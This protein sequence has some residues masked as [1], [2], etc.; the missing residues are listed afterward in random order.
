MATVQDLYAD[1]EAADAAGDT[2]KAKQLA[3]LIGEIQGAPT[4]PKPPSVGKTLATNLGGSFMNALRGA[5]A[6]AADYTGFKDTAASLDAARAAS[7]EEMKKAGSDTLLGEAAGVVGGMSPALAIE[8]AGTAAAP[9]TGGL[10]LVVANALNAGFFGIPAFRDTYKQQKEE[11]A[12]DGVAIQH[13]L[14]EASLATIGGRLIGSGSKAV[15]GAIKA[16]GEGLTKKLGVAAV[17]G[18]A[19]PEASR[20][21][22]KTIDAANN[23]ENEKSWLA[24]P[25]SMA[26]SALGFG[27]LHGVKH[28]TG[29]EGRADAKRIKDQADAAAAIAAKKQSEE[30][31]AAEQVAR[32]QDPAYLD[33]LQQRAEAF[34]KQRQELQAAAKGKADPND[35]VALAERQNAKKALA[36]FMRDEDNKA[37]IT[38]LSAGSAALRKR[39]A[40]KSQA[41]I[42]AQKQT[43]S[44]AET[45]ANA[46]QGLL[47]LQGGEGGKEQTAGEADVQP[48]KQQVGTAPDGSPLFAPD[49]MDASQHPATL[50]ASLTQ[51]IDALKAKQQAAT[52]L[53]QKI[54]IGRQHDQAIAARDEALKQAKA[55][56]PS[57]EEQIAKLQKDMAKADE[58][59]DAGTSGKLAQ[60]IKDLQETQGFPMEPFKSKVA[61][62]PN[63]LDQRDADLQKSQSPN[64]AKETYAQK[65]AREQQESAA[66]ERKQDRSNLS[67][68][69]FTQKFDSVFDNGTGG[70]RA[71]EPP[72]S[73]KPVS[74]ADKQ[75]AA[76][77]TLV[78]AI[79]KARSEKLTARRANEKE[80]ASAA[81]QRERDA[82]AQLDGLTSGDHYTRELIHR[83]YAQQSAMDTLMDVA[84][85]L[86]QGQFLGYK[87]GKNQKPAGL[88]ADLQA[89]MHDMM[90]RRE[91]LTSMD[92]KLG[93]ATDKAEVQRIT[94]ELV[95]LQQRLNEARTA[96][97]HEG[98]KDQTDLASTTKPLLYKKADKARAAYVKAMLEEAAIHR[99]ARGL[100][101]LTHEEALKAASEM[102]DLLELRSERKDGESNE[103]IQKRLKEIQDGLNNPD[104]NPTR[105]KPYENRGTQVDTVPTQET[106]LQEDRQRGLGEGKGTGVNVQYA[107]TEAARVAEEK[108]ENATTL[109]G[110]L[111]K[112]SEYVQ[113]LLEKA[114][115]RDMPANVREALEKAQA[116]LQEG[117]VTRDLLDA[118]ETQATRVLE[119]RMQGTE[120]TR[121]REL[122]KSNSALDAEGADLD[123]VRK[124][125]QERLAALNNALNKKLEKAKTDDERDVITEEFRAKR[126]ALTDKAEQEAR[127]VMRNRTEGQKKPFVQRS[128]GVGLT[129]LEELP[130][131]PEAIHDAL[132]AMRGEQPEQRGLFDKVDHKDAIAKNKEKIADLEGTI[133]FIRKS[134]MNRWI[135]VE[136]AKYRIDDAQKK[137]EALKQRN[138]ELAQEEKTQRSI[139]DQTERLGT[140]EGEQQSYETPSGFVPDDQSIYPRKSA[141]STAVLGHIRATAENFAR[142]PIVMK[143]RHAF[144]VLTG[145]TSAERARANMYQ[146]YDMA[147][148]HAIDDAGAKLQ[149]IAQKLDANAWLAT[150]YPQLRKYFFAKN[151]NGHPILDFTLE[152]IGGKE[153]D[154]TK[155]RL[156]I[157]KLRAEAAK[158]QDQLRKDLANIDEGIRKEAANDPKV[159]AAKKKL[160]KQQA[161]AGEVE[162]QKGQLQENVNEAI[163]EAHAARDRD[164]A[165]LYDSKISPLEGK[166]SGLEAQLGRVREMLHN[167][168]SQRAPAELLKT[169]MGSFEDILE[170]EFSLIAN[171]I[172][173]GI[174]KTQAEIDALRTARDTHFH[175]T[176]LAELQDNVTK[177]KDKGDPTEYEAARNAVQQHKEG[178]SESTMVTGEATKNVHVQ[179]AFKKLEKLQEK[180]ERLKEN[181]TPEEVTAAQK[182]VNEQRAHA[183]ELRRMDNEQRDS[184]YKAQNEHLTNT[185]GVKGKVL[186]LQRQLAALEA[187]A[188]AAA[189]DPK[190]AKK[191]GDNIVDLNRQILDL[192]KQ[193]AYHTGEP[194]G[195]SH[196]DVMRKS[197]WLQRKERLEAMLENPKLSDRRRARVQATLDYMNHATREMG[198][199]QGGVWRNQQPDKA[200]GGTGEKKKHMGQDRAVVDTNQIDADAATAE[201]MRRKKTPEQLEAETRAAE[202]SL[203]ES[204]R[205]AYVAQKERLEAWDGLSAAQKANI[206]AKRGTTDQLEREDRVKSMKAAERDWRR[207]QDAVN[208]HLNTGDVETFDTKS[209]GEPVLTVDKS[210]SSRGETYTSRGKVE[211]AHTVDS[212]VEELKPHFGG[213]DVRKRV[214]VFRD[215]AALLKAHPEYEGRI[216]EDAKGFVDGKHAFLIAENIG[217]GDGL[218]VLVHEI[219][220]HIGMRNLFP[221]AL[222]KALI[223]AVHDWSG[224]KDGSLESK[225]M[226]AAKARVEEAGTA[227]HKYDDE[228][229]AHAVEEAMKAGVTPTSLSG[230]GKI[231]Q[232]IGQAMQAMHKVLQRYGIATGAMKMQHLVDMAYG[233]AGKELKSTAPRHGGEKMFAYAGEKSATANNKNLAIAKAALNR[234]EHPKDVWEETGWFKGA[235]G[236]WRYELDDSKAVIETPNWALDK[237]NEW[238]WNGTPETDAKTLGDVLKHPTLYEAYPGLEKTKFTYDFEDTEFSKGA[239]KRAI[240]NSPAEIVV[241]LSN[242]DDVADVHDTVMHE[243]QHLLQATEGHEGGTNANTISMNMRNPSVSNKIASYFERKGDTA[244]RKIASVF[245]EHSAE[246][247]PLFDAYEKAKAVSAKANTAFKEHD[248]LV[249]EHDKELTGILDQ[250]HKLVEELGNID[251]FDD[252]RRQE[253]HDEIVA[254]HA[255]HREVSRAYYDKFEDLLNKSSEADDAVTKARSKMFAKSQDLLSGLTYDERSK[256]AFAGYENTYG[257]LEANDAAKRR[258]LGKFARTVIAPHTGQGTL[259]EEML[260][261]EDLMF[262]RGKSKIEEFGRDFTEQ[263]SK[264]RQLF[265]VRGGIGQAVRQG[266]MDMRASLR[267]ALS[268]GDK[269]TGVQAKTT[270]LMADSFVNNAQSVATEGA[271][272]LKKDKKGIIQVVFGGSRSGKDFMEAIADIPAKNAEA[273][274]AIMQGY[275]TA[276]RA[277]QQGWH[278]LDT[279][280]TAVTEA[281]GKAALAE[282]NADPAMKAAVEKAHDI[283]RDLNRGMIDFLEQT[284]ALP[285]D[286]IAKMK[287]DKN[288]VPF[289]RENGNN[290]EMLMPDGHPVS[291]GDIR[292]LPFLQA[293]KGDSKKLMSLPDAMLRNISTLTNLG[294][295][296]LANR[297]IGYHLA[298]IGRT[299]SGKE[300]PM[301]VRRGM[302]SEDK[303]NT[304]R[305]HEAPDPAY[306]RDTGDRYIEIDTRGTIA[307]HIPNDLLVQSVAGS[308]STF[309][310]LADVANSVGGILRTGITRNPMYVLGQLIKDPWNA[311]MSGNLKANPM[312]AIARSFK[313]FGTLM[314]GNSPE[315]QAMRQQGALPSNIYHGGKSDLNKIALQMAG[316]NQ[317]LVRRALATLD[318]MAIAADS[319]TR[320]QSYKEILAAGGSESEAASAAKELINFGR[321][322]SYAGVQFFAKT[323]PF[324]NAS[325]QGIDVLYRSVKGDM[326]AQDFYAAKQKLYNRAMGMAAIAMTYS[327]MMEDDPEWEQMSLRDKMSYIHIPRIFGE[328]DPVR[329]PAPF[330]MGMLTYSMPIAF[331][332]GLKGNYTKGDWKTIRDV[333]LAQMPGNGSVMPL[334]AKGYYDV[335]RNMNSGTG[336]Q[337]VPKSMEG[338]DPIVQYTN[339]TTEAAKRLAEELNHAGVKLSPLELEYLATTYLGSVPLFM[340]SSMNKLFKKDSEKDIAAPAGHESDLPLVG[341]WFQNQRGT[342]NIEH[343]YEMATEAKTAQDT[344]NNYKKRGKV[345]EA[346]AYLA[347]HRAEIAIAGPATNFSVTM[348]KLKQ[349]EQFIRDHKTWDEN[350]KQEKLDKLQEDRQR[351]AKQMRTILKAAEQR[352]SQQP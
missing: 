352:F 94:N 32:L 148:K 212:L 253:I 248:A 99:A 123:T 156:G 198:R 230:K 186:P 205:K 340:A 153:F 1:M 341:R 145:T 34:N 138:D 174:R 149:E 124:P 129:E 107:K 284:H 106:L 134:A 309:W 236:K 299:A 89:E 54:N 297:Q 348:D 154:A 88:V 203:A 125:H 81:F 280:N 266:V 47:D 349:Y 268:L 126:K 333:F 52:D 191:A 208:K 35:P 147:R 63:D 150:A 281:K 327:L 2:A 163:R 50:A 83:K 260:Q 9:I 304:L 262:S 238:Q 218:S 228:L 335:S 298:G 66:D 102:H 59:G 131:Y 141:L 220:V 188:T 37:L 344:F 3:Q 111:R 315:A 282:V 346:K 77:D 101:P 227:K 289:F 90:V 5:G 258:G 31:A 320:I 300:K 28:V 24:D 342:D 211:N 29:G 44:E 132:A 75:Q 225:I 257:E 331:M 322:G 325:L 313:E 305:W 133:K 53:D 69:E 214:G 45:K 58:I 80:A 192:Q 86:R 350:V 239:F 196:K 56:G 93:K 25:Q 229:L 244:S 259:R 36:E 115:G 235:D 256:A 43:D 319:A 197:E 172:R 13:A 105:V 321:H 219:G 224:R 334:I 306:P 100:K 42:D 247:Q 78:A 157:D 95:K 97:T 113:N 169:K 19:F 261:S 146:Q 162:E 71:V 181:G 324:F 173:E 317:S 17:E 16:G 347:E 295:T 68:T 6:A 142:S 21:A 200:S 180:L 294:I 67:D 277:E 296:N 85:R 243:V 221:P 276:K 328:H 87:F 84:E 82:M 121:S 18:A 159:L 166:I 185:Q 136:V 312:T 250:E 164:L 72:A 336:Q 234:G 118:T 40:E 274:I 286:V 183:D 217:K 92:P 329:I 240:G 64:K 326:P 12:S 264:V 275:L 117:K 143:M 98:D 271:A 223:R 337:I 318:R 4:T 246:I 15:V 91:V 114:L 316:D 23:R 241:N 249:G 122:S 33:D 139:A 179:D 171:P 202:V 307:E 96:V 151:A 204:L 10:S 110:E 14:A 73:V 302:P 109:S 233:A 170:H 222:Y 263:R 343:M 242:A 57:V 46:E 41:E 345:E 310:A 177:A 270:Q 323:I 178:A 39:Q 291:I 189:R 135:A 201:M 311:S 351:Y 273:R 209:V 288:Y 226:E 76:V 74:D 140:T 195:G 49:A 293:L 103:F 168:L 332:E 279:D 231:G 290:I 267:N 176:R 152:R 158:L 160:A 108:G 120:T 65:Q 70:E 338:L 213:Q 11:G 104:T 194:I 308:Y 255:K 161:A 55:L 207:A 167:V 252:P 303:Q 272:M 210:K 314:W 61:E 237:D 182:E 62:T 265:D 130:Q 269:D 301:Q 30:A 128:R 116:A 215:I 278:T 175:D 199:V 254:L 48:P 245:R 287:A 51:H 26:A 38:E 60:R 7:Q 187:R 339:K 8:A 79:N 206:V 292:S 119:G 232:W 190:A 330:E 193:I 165:E 137:I 27:A 112:H 127:E 251:T 184:I 285:A 144:E 155:E 283:Y 20:V 22:E 216:P